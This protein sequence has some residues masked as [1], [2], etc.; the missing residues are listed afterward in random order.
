M[1]VFHTL[2]EQ[3]FWVV[4]LH[5]RKDKKPDDKRS[6][7]YC[8]NPLIKRQDETDFES[9]PDDDV[10]GADDFGLQNVEPQ[11]RGETDAERGAPKGGKD[12]HCERAY[13]RL[14]AGLCGTGRQHRA[15]H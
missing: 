10:C 14:G 8:N 12:R 11:H 6:L 2:G 15:H 5:R 13:S 4:T 1:A 9:S 7:N 3:L